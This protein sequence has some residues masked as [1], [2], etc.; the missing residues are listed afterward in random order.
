MSRVF[1]TQQTMKKDRQTGL[2]SPKFDLSPAEEWGDIECLLTPNAKPFD[3][4]L[5]LPE[6][7][8]QLRVVEDDD[9]L[10]P[11]G[12]PA[13]MCW[14]GGIFPLYRQGDISILQWN[15]RDGYTEITANIFD[16]MEGDDL[17][18]LR[19]ELNARIDA[20]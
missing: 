8:E 4:P 18:A 13:F 9:T 5:V 1:L 7:H 16:D 3:P 6:L 15:R 19:D 11:T 17:I 14:T 12:S 10:L 20:L 2:L